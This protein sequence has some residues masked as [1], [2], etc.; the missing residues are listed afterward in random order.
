[1][2]RSNR[3]FPAIYGIACL[4]MLTLAG[5]ATA[6]EAPSL[7]EDFAGG[8]LPDRWRVALGDFRVEEGTLVAAE[9]PSDMH[10]GVLVIPRPNRDVAV[11]FDFR[12]D[13]A[14]ALHLSFDVAPGT[15]QRKG[16]LFR[17]VLRPDGMTLQ[18][19]LDKSNPAVKGAKLAEAK[20]AFEPGKWY[21]VHLEH[22]GPEVSARVGEGA[23]VRASDA[24]LAH[25]KPGLRFVITGQSARIDNVKLWD[26]AAGGS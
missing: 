13:G 12:L 6:A 21:T 10:N 3:S 16:H 24:H 5:L 17:L 26:L 14:K 7:Q 9:R 19:D 1:M 22:R 8:K 23:M 4:C 25:A 18:R 11:S 2:T 15:P 20:R